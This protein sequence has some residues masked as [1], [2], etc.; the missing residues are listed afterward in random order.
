MRI[1]MLA[2]ALSAA[3]VAD[4]RAETTPYQPSALSRAHHG[5][6]ET[7]LDANRVRISFSGNAET[8]RETVETYLLYRAAELTLQRS[9]DYFVV[10]DHNVETRTEYAAAGPPV[11]PIAP[12]RRYREISSYSAMS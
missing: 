12:P 9:Y 4:A 8:S 1:L 3:V 5:Y 6:A 11:P 2:A 10:A 7:P